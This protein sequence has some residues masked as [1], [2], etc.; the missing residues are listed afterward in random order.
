M[1]RFLLNKNNEKAN[2]MTDNLKVKEQ[3]NKQAANFNDWPVTQ[4][5]KIHRALYNFFGIKADERLLDFACGT[6]AFAVYAAQRTK[7][8]QGVDI[9]E[10]MIEIAV[11]SAEQRVLKNIAFLCCDVEKVPLESDDFDCVISKSAFHHMKN[12]K[13]VF[14][15]MIRCCKKQGRIGIEDVISYDDKK[16]DD[17]F[18]KLECEIDISHNVSLPKTEI[19]N[20]Y[21]KNGVEIFRLFE[22][23]SEL[24]FIDY[25]N[26]AVQTEDAGQ[27]IST[28]LETGLKDDQ[29]SKWFVTRNNALFWR[30]K[31]LTI[32]GRK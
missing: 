23:I 16:T 12:Y 19:I 28:L 13:T 3:F 30:R 6:G 29:I 10:G 24:N 31:V 7:A 15:E 2:V 17:F 9:S 14:K 25:V 20:L 22:S 21:K 27:K 32:V 18:E 26:H 11:E 4:E 1:P 8:V 5:E